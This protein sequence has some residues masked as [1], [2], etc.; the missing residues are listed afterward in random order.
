MFNHFPANTEI[1]TK[2]G[3]AKNL[4]LNGS[5][6]LNVDSW[7]PRCYDLSQHSQLEELLDDYKCTALQITIKKHYKMFKELC[8]S[9]METAIQKVQELKKKRDSGVKYNYKDD[10]SELMF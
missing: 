3:L 10:K 9:Q 7:F 8:K 5:P 6:S 1:T 2:S 4:Y